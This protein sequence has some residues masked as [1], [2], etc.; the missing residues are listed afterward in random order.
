MSAMAMKL[1]SGLTAG[2]VLQRLGARGA[3][4]LLTGTADGDG[5]IRATLL[6]S[7]A[8]IKGWNNRNVG[9]I[10]GGKFRV[11]LSPLPVGGPYRLRLEAGDQRLE[12]APIFVGDVW[13]LAGQSNMEGVGDM[14]G[15]AKAHPLICA[16]SMRR[17]W[18]LAEDP[19][20][21]LD[22]SPDAC[23]SPAPCSVE[24]GERLRATKPKGVGVGVFFAREM[25]Q[26]SGG[27]PQGLICTAHGGTSMQQ[28]SPSGKRLG[29]KSLYASMLMSVRATGQPVAGLLWYQG[30]SD[31]N[32]ADAP[33]YTRRMKKLVATSRHD[34]RQPKLPWMIVQ[35]A[36]HFCEGVDSSGW[37][38]VRDQQRLLPDKIAFLETVAAIDLPLD[39]PIHIGS[40]GFDRLGRRLARVADRLVY[41]NRQ[42]ARPPRI[43]SARLVEGGASPT[44]EVEIDDVSVGLRSEGEPRGFAWVNEGGN[45]LNLIY[46]SEIRGN[47]VALHLARKPDARAH[48]Y[49]GYGYVPTCNITDSRDFSLP[50][51][52]PL[53]VKNLKP[54]AL[55]PFVTEW[56]ATPIVPA[57]K[58]LDEVTLEEI[59]ALD[60]TVRSFPGE[61]MVNEHGLWEGQ[62]GH[63]FFRARL[64]LVESMKLKFLLGYDGPFRLWLD[65]NAVFTDMA[66]INPC[67]PDERMHKAK[68]AAGA[69]DICVGMDLNGGRAWGFFL[70]FERLDTT[71]AQRR[72]GNFVKPTYSV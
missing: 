45:V 51:G 34:L 9:R 63:A 4:V 64:N 39:D 56:N 48:L 72:S 17:E 67:I 13:I 52:G 35:I 8:A 49:Y 3:E 31:A 50:A 43:R 23:H 5:L 54:Q 69:H 18:R 61:G 14:T 46:K 66:G 29:G 32:T 36:R 57:A 20:H 25:L 24:V 53:G 42:E 62:G 26:R 70:R 41:G 37:N 10:A 12:I 7:K 30:E 55:A 6:K 11:K 27:V 40:A 15:A 44:V 58:P 19:L 65:G 16:F 22:E 33:K 21:I 60:T 47:K 71:A 59:E 38:S 2:Q 68:L 1:I 28:W